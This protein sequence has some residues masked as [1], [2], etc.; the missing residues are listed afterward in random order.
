MYGNVQRESGYADHLLRFLLGA[1]GINAVG[2][3]PAK[4]GFYG[5]TWKVDAAGHSYF[6]K[7]DYAAAHKRVY[8]RSFPVVEHLRERG[9]DCISRIVKTVDGGLSARYGG[10]VLGVFDWIDG[11]NIQDKR[12]KHAE[13]QMLA[14]IYTIPA[15]RLSIPREDFSGDSAD[16]FYAQWDALDDA[17]LQSLLAEN[18]AVLAHR[19]A[20]LKCFATLCCGDT[21]GFAITHGDAGGN[22]IRTGEGHR[23]VD[24]D[25]PILAPPERDAWFGC[26]YPSLSDW[27]VNTFHD[28]LRAN[29]I[30]YRLRPE[31]LAYYCYHSF[32]FYLTEYLNAYFDL[33]NPNGCMAKCL[34]AYFHCWIEEQ[35]K[36]ADKHF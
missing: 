36:Y 28:A 29:R 2:I 15:D 13:Y 23:I 26:L 32:F 22:V 21:T 11:E 27:A 17:Q 10:A 20:R 31:R 9:I 6:V 35:I 25:D 3:A 16:C 18:S 7:L 1:Y 19:A 4:R 5:E 8:E 12:T 24:W 30:G 14:K 34:D 33:G